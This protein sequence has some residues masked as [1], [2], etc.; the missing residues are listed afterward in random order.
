MF[1][2]KLTQ[3][4]KEAAF[5]LA[6]N[7]AAADNDISEEEIEHLKHFSKA[8]DIPFTLEQEEFNLKELVSV[9]DTQCS[10]IILLQELIELSYRDGHF[11]DEE[12]EKVI[13]VAQ[14]LGIFDADL[15]LK[16]EVWVR[17]GFNMLS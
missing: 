10:K 15:I 14:K 11:G 2:Y 16:I 5:K 7:L 13:S 1:L 17:D 8:F 6:V 4:Q 9:F 12:Q 3:S